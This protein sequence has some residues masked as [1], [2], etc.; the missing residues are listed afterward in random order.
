L[1]DIEKR[2]IRTP[3]EPLV[4]FTDDPLRVLRCF[5]FKS[6]F[7][8]TIHDDIYNSLLNEGVHE[9][10]RTKVSK[11]RIGI[12]LAGTL[13]APYALTGLWEIYK[14]KF[15]N[16]IF[17]VP[18][19]SDLKDPQL[20]ARIP[21]F[22]FRLIEKGK[23]LIEKYKLLTEPNLLEA[24]GKEE[25]DRRVRYTAEELKFNINLSFITVAYRHY[26]VVEGKKSTPLIDH[27]ARN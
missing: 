16:I 7:N 4:T 23:E 1:S 25:K 9:A 24:E 19:E 2:V 21:E 13:K 5:R 11:E 15:W 26:K 3:L 14:Y 22:S 17:E 18:S 12:E 10:L 6:R 27:I 20:I 8:F